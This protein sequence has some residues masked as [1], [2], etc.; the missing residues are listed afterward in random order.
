M[1]RWHTRR[2]HLSLLDALAASSRR[3]SWPQGLV[4]LAWSLWCLDV[5][6]PVTAQ[7]SLTRNLSTARKSSSSFWE[8]RRPTAAEGPLWDAQVSSR[9]ESAVTRFG[10][11][12]DTFVV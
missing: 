5:P 7:L 8:D 3:L 12:P 6:P 9:R 4:G 2:T 1:G 11:C 10:H